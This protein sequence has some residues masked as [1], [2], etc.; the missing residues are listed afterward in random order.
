MTLTKRGSKIEVMKDGDLICFSY[1]TNR[2]W[3][4]KPDLER[5]TKFLTSFG[6]KQKK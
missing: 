1:G 4:I 5:F 2:E 6:Y 3:I